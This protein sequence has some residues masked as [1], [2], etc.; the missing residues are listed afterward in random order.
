VPQYNGHGFN[1]IGLPG[2][3]T[4]AGRFVR[5]FVAKNLA[6]TSTRP[7]TEIEALTLGAHLLNAV[8]VAD[9]VVAKNAMIEPLYRTTWATLKSPSTGLFMWRSYMNLR[10]QS[11]NMTDLDAFFGSSSAPRSVQVYMPGFG[12]NDVTGELLQSK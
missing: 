1:L 11:I 7:K 3:L 9:G 2:D 10:W 12:N 5:T 4:S 6:V 8:D